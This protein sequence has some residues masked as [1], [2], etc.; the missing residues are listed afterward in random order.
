[1]DA[2]VTDGGFRETGG[3]SPERTNLVAERLGLR[4]YR[5]GVT[6][7]V[8]V[9]TFSD[10]A[11]W[12]KVR[13]TTVWRGLRLF[14]HD[15]ATVVRRVQ[16]SGAGVA[17]VAEG[18]QRILV[19]GDGVDVELTGS[20]PAAQLRR[21]AGGLGVRGTVLPAD[22]AEASTTDLAGGAGCPA[23]PAASRRDRRLQPARRARR[24]WHRDAQLHRVG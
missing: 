11:A 7:G 6:A 8:Q 23:Q 21:V 12:V 4:P 10:G 16:L 2:A 14:G 1:M 5:D 13:S 20:V 24:R 18:G 9:Q 19:H 15:T 22:W 3:R 17:F